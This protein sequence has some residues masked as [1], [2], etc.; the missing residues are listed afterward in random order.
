MPIRWATS[1][2][3][4]GPTSTV[5][6][7]K[8]V[9]TEPAIAFSIDIVPADWSPAFDRLHGCPSVSQNGSGI[10]IDEGPARTSSGEI[11]RS[12]AATRTNGLNALPACRRA[13]VAR[14]NSL[15]AK[16][17]PPTIARIAPLLGSIAT[18]AASGSD[19][20]GREVRIARS[21]AR[22]HSMSRVVRTRSP[23]R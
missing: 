11:P 22:C 18:S 14:L 2:T 10:V 17:L 4:S 19:R 8:I 7:A 20:D 12:R 15:R 3:A 9:F 1:A 6:C 23:P 16:L 21:A 5:S 13:C